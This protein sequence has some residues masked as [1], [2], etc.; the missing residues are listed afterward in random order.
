MA[1]KS[2]PMTV[3]WLDHITIPTND[4]TRWVKWGVR[5]LGLQPGPFEGLS[6]DEQHHHVPIHGFMAI[7]G[8]DV[9]PELYGSTPHHVGVFVLPEQMEKS[10][11]ALGQ[12]TPRY[13]FYIRAKDIDQHMARLEK[14][15]YLARNP[16]ITNTNV[17]GSGITSTQPY[18]DPIRTTIAGEDGTIIYFE[19]PDGSQW[20][21]WAPDKM[22]EGAMDDC[23]PLGVGRLSSATYGSQDLQKTADFFSKFCGLEPFEGGGGS[24]D[25]LVL[26]LAGGPTM[27]YRLVTEPDQRTKEGTG[28]GLHAA[29][30]VVAEDFVPMYEELWDKVPEWDGPPK[31]GPE[32]PP[33]R[34]EMH[35]SLVGRRWKKLLGRGDYFFDG[36]GHTFHFQGCFSKTKNATLTNY[37]SKDDELYLEELAA[38]RGLT[39]PNAKVIA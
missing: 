16:E 9:P 4:L 3:Y 33:Y 20:E 13:G 6:T 29:L 27:T 10:T 35:G 36:D 8:R 37:D 19:D 28:I 24:N 38:A 23:T 26:P 31:S 32:V 11:A 17:H 2:G 39:I 30:A 1:Q 21:F 7:E 22:P 5:T 18:S 25:T 15:D 12:G 34:T 14:A